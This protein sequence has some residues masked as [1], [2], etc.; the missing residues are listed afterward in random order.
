M[1]ASL[2][3]AQPEKC[4]LLNSV[5]LFPKGLVHYYHQVFFR[6]TFGPAPV[7]S[8]DEGSLPLL[9][10]ELPIATKRFKS[11][12]AP[13]SPTNDLERPDSRNNAKSQAHL[14][15]LAVPYCVW[16]HTVHQCEVDSGILVGCTSK[17]TVHLREKGEYSVRIRG[18]PSVLHTYSVHVCSFGFKFFLC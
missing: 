7:H 2:A 3:H 15:L 16:V 13:S 14:P 12:K 17:E 5:K 8:N 9:F 1:R 11:P 10:Y 4:T 18:Q 6:S